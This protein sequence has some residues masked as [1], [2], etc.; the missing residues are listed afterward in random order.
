MQKAATS[1]YEHAKKK[2]SK[3]IILNA[4]YPKKMLVAIRYRYQKDYR[5]RL[6]K[7]LCSV[8]GRGVILIITVSFVQLQ[9]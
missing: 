1:R 3:A 8:L 9:K 5:T 4:I 2:G 7:Q 6:S